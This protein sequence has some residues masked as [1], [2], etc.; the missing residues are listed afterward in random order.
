M[1]Y[2][3]FGQLFQQFQERSGCSDC[4]LALFSGLRASLEEIKHGRGELDFR[5][6]E[7]M[8]EALGLY[9]FELQQ[10]LEAGE[11]HW[12][13]FR[14]T[15]FLRFSLRSPSRVTKAVLPAQLVFDF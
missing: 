10:L 3:E 11:V 13:N 6:L 8:A 7:A 4:Y 12:P 2:P 1:N 5:T 14:T 9:E 15:L